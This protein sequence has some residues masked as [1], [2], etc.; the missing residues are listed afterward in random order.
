MEEWI[1]RETAFSGRLIRIDRGTVRLD[2]GRETQREVMVHPG[3]VGVVPVVG[4]SV[5]LVRQFRI[6]IGRD[7]LEIP[8]GKFEPGDTPELRARLELEEE[9]GLTLGRLVPIGVMYPS[10]GFLSEVLHLFLAFDLREVPARPE[11]DERIEVVRMSLDD[12]RRRL[13]AHEFEDAK[14]RVGL[15]ALFDSVERG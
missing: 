7:M 1:H 4:D 8:A 12:A 13:R 11:W 14:T 6:A 10:V 2:D 15:H 9:A 3:G 5:V